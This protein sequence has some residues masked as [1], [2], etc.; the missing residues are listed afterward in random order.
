MVSGPFDN[1]SRV[2]VSPEPASKFSSPIYVEPNP[3]VEGQ[4]FDNILPRSGG[5]GASVDF[6][7]VPSQC[8]IRIF[9]LDGDLVQVLKH[10]DQNSSRVRWNLFN[11]GRRPVASGIYLFSADVAGSSSFA[12][13]PDQVLEAFPPAPTLSVSFPRIG[14]CELPVKP[15][16]PIPVPQVQTGV[17]V[18]PASAAEEFRKLFEFLCSEGN[19]GLA[20][21][22]ITSNCPGSAF[23]KNSCSCLCQATK[24]TKRRFSI[25]VRPVS[26]NSKT[27]E[28]HDGQVVEKVPTPS[29]TPVTRGD[30]ENPNITMPE[31]TDAGPGAINFGGFNFGYFSRSGDCIVS[32]KWQLFVHEFC[33]HGV[34]KQRIQNAKIFGCRPAHDETIITENAI[35]K[36]VAGAGSACGT[37]ETARQGESF[38]KFGSQGAL[39]FTLADGRYFEDCQPVKRASNFK[40]CQ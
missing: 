7:N 9:T 33:G 13:R 2:L 29:V 15:V 31:S 27:V 24:S 19:F 21:N 26:N 18:E 34:L 22:R 28:L 20:G 23:S 25:I 10:D 38:V 6:V 5:D 30:R 14:P 32:A 37:F 1:L 16:P 12:A 40:K 8:T 39:L 35:A 4:G 36:D 17:F 3:Y 11:K